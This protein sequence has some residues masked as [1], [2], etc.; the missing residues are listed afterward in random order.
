[1]T[2]PTPE[3]VAED[4]DAYLLVPPSTARAER[5]GVVLIDYGGPSALFRLAARIRFEGDV[6]T[7]IDSIRTWFRERGLDAFTWKLGLHTLPLDLEA[8]LRAHGAHEDEAE[9]EH[10]AM[11]LDHEPPGVQGIQVRAVASYA[12]YVTTAEIMAVGFGGSFSDQERAAMRQQL[13]QRF[14]EYRDHPTGRRYLALL[15]GEPIAV[16]NARLTTAG[17][18]ALAGGATLPEARSHGAY[19]ALV[20][21]RWDDAVAA[22]TP[23]LV[24]Q[25]SALSRPI[26]ERLGFVAVGPVLELIDSTDRRPVTR[27]LSDR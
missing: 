18:V 14:A 6:G 8:R 19:R 24:T 25:A 13:A 7:A 10:T 26:L 12:D 15:D 2:W 17:V 20:R 1:M 27:R 21:A 5:P 22:G 11:L 9:P 4:L 16:G 23:V 3:A